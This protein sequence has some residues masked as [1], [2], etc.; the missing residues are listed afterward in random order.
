MAEQVEDEIIGSGERGVVLVGNMHAF[1]HYRQPVVKDGK[2]VSEASPRMA[3]LLHE[4]HGERVFHLTLQLADISP[5]L[6]DPSYQGEK[7]RLVDLVEE[8]MAKLGNEPVGFDVFASPLATLRDSRS[9][10]F[11]YQPDVV[12]ADVCRGY[13]FLAPR[14]ELRHCE[15]IPG[16]VSD[17]MFSE[18]RDFL[19]ARFSRKFASAKEVNSTFAAAS[20][21]RP[22]H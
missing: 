15:W 9:Y 1:T 13:L 10:Y 14:K 3:H 22:G 4:R 8:V 2:F 18:N 12:F 11:H 7:P 5:S 21:E 17:H 19:E 6:A 20:G 16:F